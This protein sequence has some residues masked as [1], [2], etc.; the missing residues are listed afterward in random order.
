MKRELENSRNPDWSLKKLTENKKG[1]GSQRIEKMCKWSSRS[2]GEI[3]SRSSVGRDKC[4]TYFRMMQEF[5]RSRKLNESQ[6][7]LKKKIPM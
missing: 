2:R 6:T 7:G 4:L 1:F 5:S 3:L